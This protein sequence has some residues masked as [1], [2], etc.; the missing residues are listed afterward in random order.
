MSADNI[1]DILRYCFIAVKFND[2]PVMSAAFL[3]ANKQATQ[4]A[5]SGRKPY[6]YTYDMVKQHVAKINGE[7]QDLGLSCASAILLIFI[8]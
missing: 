5:C 1:S 2:M 4:V 8:I 3:G 7:Y 6:F